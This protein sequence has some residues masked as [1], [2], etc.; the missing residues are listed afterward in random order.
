MAPYKRALYRLLAL[1]VLT[2][3]SLSYSYTINHDAW[4]SIDLDQHVQSDNTMTGVV[5]AKKI[6][7]FNLQNVALEAWSLVSTVEDSLLAVPQGDGSFLSL[8]VSETKNISKALQQQYPSLRTW[9]ITPN[10]DIISGAITSSDSGLKVR[11]HLKSGEVVQIAPVANNSLDNAV[12]L[13]KVWVSTE[14][15]GS[16]HDVYKEHILSSSDTLAEDTGRRLRARNAQP[17]EGVIKKYRLAVTTTGEYAQYHGGT[18]EL[19]LA[20]IVH[21]IAQINE[22]YERD[23]GVR[24]EIIDNN[25]QLIYTNPEQDPFVNHSPAEIV[26][27]NQRLLST[28]I[29]AENYDIAHVFSTSG[30]GLAYTSGICDDDHKA[31]GYSGIAKPEGTRFAIDFV[32]HELGHQLGASHTFN[33]VQNLCGSHRVALSAVEPG[34]GST[35]MSYAGFC[36][37]DN[38][39]FSVDSMFHATS[40]E[41]IRNNIWTSSVGSQCGELV[42]HANQAPQ[43]DTS[44]E[45]VIPA[46]TPFQ[47]EAEAT[48]PEGDAVQYSW[49]QIDAGAASEYN[50]DKNNNA[51]FRTYLPQS[52]NKRTIPS[53]DNLLDGVIVAGETLPSKSRNLN[54][55]V[56]AYDTHHNLSRKDMTIQVF[57]SGRGFAFKDFPYPLESGQTYTLDWDT[58]DT[59][60]APVSC[61]SVD[62]YLS[63]NGDDDF[64]VPLAVAVENSGRAVVQLP[65]NL[66][67][68]E[69]ARMK[70]SCSNNIFFA[71][72]PS[73]N[74]LSG[75]NEFEA[76]SVA[77]I[78]DNNNVVLA[79]ASSGGGGSMGILN[80]IFFL[81]VMMS[82][83]RRRRK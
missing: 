48:D 46:H 21:T 29:G 82:V 74:E 22:V 6:H 35:I 72:S 20:A 63:T 2:L 26:A 7:Y 69:N 54:I 25:H 58:A 14:S 12:T 30:G 73:V 47:L 18:A 41:Q 77:T 81:I 64:S 60:Y 5:S 49:H 78:E 33:S 9:K 76:D 42:E 70:L 66:E 10:T 34:S 59:E 31:M 51:L 43:L 28:I 13:H 45:Y 68:A 50:Q 79:A 24:L 38:L 65:R 15:I 8:H 11:L 36:S 55:A 40:I 56:L 23:L 32:A 16:A 4:Q 57:D 44:A 3:P 62:I 37:T 61:H 19:A 39:Q 52:E 27:V 67:H 80:S 1:W 53:M 71:I 83:I 17:L 75:R